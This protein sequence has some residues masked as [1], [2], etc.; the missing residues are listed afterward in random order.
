MKFNYKIFSNSEMVRSG[1]VIKVNNQ[2]AEVCGL[3]SAKSNQFIRVLTSDKTIIKGYVLELSKNKASVALLG[4]D[5]K[6]SPGNFVYVSKK[7]GAF[8]RVGSSLLGHILNGVADCVDGTE[9]FTNKELKHL[10]YR[11][12]SIEYL[13]A[14]NIFSSN[15]DNVLNAFFNAFSSNCISPSKKIA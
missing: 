2:L 12:L 1:Y 6:V 9:V 10:A 7:G 14:L 11:K 5:R 4:N 13:S 8:I 15:V 3:L